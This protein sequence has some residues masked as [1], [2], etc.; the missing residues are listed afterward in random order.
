M[1]PV[2]E[3]E[4]CFPPLFNR[5]IQTSKGRV[6][7]FRLVNVDDET[8]GAERCVMRTGSHQ[9]VDRYSKYRHHTVSKLCQY[10][11]SKTVSLFLSPAF[12]QIT[13]P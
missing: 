6:L 7:C 4:L 9:I 5:T 10:E 13:T 1:T 11:V 8:E 3:E 12:D 2:K